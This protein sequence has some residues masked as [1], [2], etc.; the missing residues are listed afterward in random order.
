MLM[1]GTLRF[2][3]LKRRNRKS[4][5]IENLRNNCHV[6]GRFKNYPLRIYAC[7]TVISKIGFRIYYDLVLLGIYFPFDL[8]LSISCY[9]IPKMK[10]SRGTGQHI[11]KSA[12]GA[13]R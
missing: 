7:I 10:V 6:K 1:I 2:L 11:N 13:G 12:R 8:F 4:V 9:F 5:K 3:R